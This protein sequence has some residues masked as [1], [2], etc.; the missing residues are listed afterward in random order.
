MS[1][2]QLGRP[3]GNLL[4]RTITAE[5]N[6]KCIRY[7]I[8]AAGDAITEPEEW[9]PPE[10]TAEE[11]LKAQRQIRVISRT[12]DGNRII[13]GVGKPKSANRP[14]REALAEAIKTL[15]ISELTEKFQCGKG[16]VARWISEFGL[17]RDKREIMKQRNLE[18][19]QKKKNIITIKLK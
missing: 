19:W 6:N 14:T 16:S 9:S 15:K 1:K 11:E 4:P 12:A 5:Q 3:R 7:F 8:D 13:R 17:Q 18:R 2:N 10:L